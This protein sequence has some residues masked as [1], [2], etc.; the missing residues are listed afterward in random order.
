MKKKS[1]LIGILAIANI[2][3]SSCNNELDEL[4]NN[5]QKTAIASRAIASPITEKIDF[6]YKGLHYEAISTVIND[7]IISIDNPAIEALLLELDQKPNLVTFSYPD[8][9]CEYF[10]DTDDF[11]A[12]KE[13]AFNQSIEKE[14]NAIQFIL[15]RGTIDSPNAQYVANLFLHDD[16]NYEDRKREFDLAEGQKELVINQ[17]R[18]YSMNDKTTSFVAITMKGNTLFELFEDDHCRSHCF[19]F[20]VTPST[21]MG[22]NSGERATAIPHGLVCAPNLKNVHVK[23][24]KRSSWN[25]RITSIRMTRQ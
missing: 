9:T 3:L 11:N 24:T 8:G 23:G 6:L 21:H 10:D 1:V 7:S 16:R 18:D 22:I 19:S 17:L 4:D 15:P 20:L 25:D 5:E 14:K 12:N 13:R 2:G